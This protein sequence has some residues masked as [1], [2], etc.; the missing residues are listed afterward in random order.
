MSIKS[1]FKRFFDVDED[2]VEEELDA[3]VE[4]SKSD[5]EQ[6]DRTQNVVSLQS[7]QQSAKMVLIEPRT[8]EEAQDVADHLKNRR[9]VILNMQRIQKDQ[10]KRIVDFLSGTVYAIGGDIQKIG[11]N[12]FLCTPDNVEISGAISELMQ[13]DF[14]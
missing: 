1:R 8:Y 3:P 5:S 4:E 2:Y 10:A 13:Q 11:G 6:K 9:S 12:I 7:I 14:D